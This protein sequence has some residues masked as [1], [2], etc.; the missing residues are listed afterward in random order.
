MLSVYLIFT[1]EIHVQRKT[2]L[3]SSPLKTGRM[4]LNIEID[5]HIKTRYINH[6]G[7]ARGFTRRQPNLTLRYEYIV[8]GSIFGTNFYK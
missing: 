4:F 3:V 8:N 1:C 7:S 6:A 5:R 2:H